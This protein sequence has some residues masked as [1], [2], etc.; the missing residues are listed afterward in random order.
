V[1]GTT[2]SEGKYNLGPFPRDL[3]YTV[4]AEK[5]GYIISEAETK[6]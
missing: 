4:R 3:T 5:L 2:D 6:G 1:V